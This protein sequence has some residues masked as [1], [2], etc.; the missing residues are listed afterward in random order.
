MSSLFNTCPKKVTDNSGYANRVMSGRPDAE[1]VDMSWRY[2]RESTKKT[3]TR[4]VVSIKDNKRSESSESF[5]ERVDEFEWD[6]PKFMRNYDS[7]QDEM[8]NRN[9]NLRDFK[10]A[11]KSLSSENY[12]AHI[13]YLACIAA[14]FVINK[15]VGECPQGIT[16]ISDAIVP[17]LNH[18]TKYELTF[19]KN[20]T[21]PKE[22]S[23]PSFENCYENDARMALFGATF[24]SSCAAAR[25]TPNVSNTDFSSAGETSN[26]LCKT[27]FFHLDEPSILAFSLMPLISSERFYNMD[28]SWVEIGRAMRSSHPQ[29]PISALTLWVEHTSQ[30]YLLYK[31]RKWVETRYVPENG[32]PHSK[33]YIFPKNLLKGVSDRKLIAWAFT[34]N[35]GFKRFISESVNDEN[36]YNISK[37]GCVNISY[38]IVGD[39]LYT[40]NTTKNNSVRRG[41]CENIV[42]NMRISS[43]PTEVLT[44]ACNDPFLSRTFG[45][46]S[47]IAPDDIVRNIGKSKKTTTPGS[48]FSDFMSFREFYK[49]TYDKHHS[50]MFENYLHKRK[51]ISNLKNYPSGHSDNDDDTDDTDRLK[52]HKQEAVAMEKACSKNVKT[53]LTLPTHSTNVYENDKYD[54]DLVMKEDESESAVKIIEDVTKTLS[55][56]INENFYKRASMID[57]KSATP[58]DYE[59]SEMQEIN[60]VLMYFHFLRSKKHKMAKKGEETKNTIRMKLSDKYPVINKLLDDITS[61]ND[62]T[63]FEKDFEDV[64]EE[65]KKATSTGDFEDISKSPVENSKASSAEYVIDDSDSDDDDET[66][67]KGRLPFE[68]DKDIED[69][70]ETIASM[71]DQV[72]INST[73]GI[74]L[75]AIQ[76]C[77][78]I[79]IMKK[80]LKAWKCFQMKNL[81][82]RSRLLV[83]M[84]LRMNQNVIASGM[85]TGYSLQCFPR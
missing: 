84:Q 66:S 28:T 82:P 83:H 41:Q 22:Y 36:F 81:A 10:S 80:C 64:E 16:T 45:Y 3:N 20:G 33:K 11:L 35:G 8:A 70:L 34:E 85:K 38:D 44:H 73:I 63:S 39:V 48:I 40:R 76:I 15:D 9:I 47:E 43:T 12:K 25:V 2:E 17:F 19:V 30:K 49:E 52:H 77:P 71:N 7:F 51:D 42:N 57:Y 31:I 32:V 61:F 37:Y 1:G 50:N 74:A 53:R 65:E 68:S 26:F 23:L 46:F 14:L 56:K 18:R 13:G 58:E 67:E 21:V 6:V 24:S 5:K 75:D 29:T 62:I 72:E 54:T 55:L 59:W 4:A 60:C 78:E 69:F 27:S 79:G